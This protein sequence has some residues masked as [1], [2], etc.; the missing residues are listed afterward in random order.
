MVEVMDKGQVLPHHLLPLLLVEG[1]T[2]QV[3]A[4]LQVG[5]PIQE[6]LQLEEK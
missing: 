3:E 4:A 6:T 1:K 2:L 5:H